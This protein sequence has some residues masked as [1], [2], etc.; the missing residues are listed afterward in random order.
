MN[1]A[2]TNL[3]LLSISGSFHAIIHCTCV[4]YLYFTLTL[5]VTVLL[6]AWVI[7]IALVHN[8]RSIESRFLCTVLHVKVNCQCDS[9]GSNTD[10]IIIGTNDET[11]FTAERHRRFYL[12]VADPAPCNGTINSWRYCFY[13]PFSIDDGHDYK[14]TFAVYRRV[15]TNYQKSI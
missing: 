11:A 1:S 4:A 12:N 8:H 9:T 13:K 14:T 3:I 10:T 7:A 15:G 5:A 2:V 6:Y